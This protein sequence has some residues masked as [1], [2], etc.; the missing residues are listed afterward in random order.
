MRRPNVRTTDIGENKQF[1]F[2]GP[3]SIFNKII[4]ENFPNLKKDM[5]MNIQETYRTP[6]R[7][8]QEK[9]SS[10][11]IRIKPPNAQNKERLLKALRGKGQV[12]YKGKPIRI[13]PDFSPETIKA[14]RSWEG[15]IQDIR[16]HKCQPRLLYPAKLSITIRGETKIFH[17]KNK[18]MQYLSTGAAL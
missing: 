7:L 8:K 9:N 10:H 5:S 12:T 16:E 6:N 17:D 3:V 14:R 1:Q 13:I 15:I 18:F 4:E 11:Y 2:K